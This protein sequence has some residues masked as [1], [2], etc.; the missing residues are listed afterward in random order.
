MLQKA[1]NTAFAISELL[2]NNQQ[3]RLKDLLQGKG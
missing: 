3:R 1:R 2:R